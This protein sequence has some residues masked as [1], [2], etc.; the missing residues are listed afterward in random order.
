MIGN[1]HTERMK[2]GQSTTH[3][4]SAVESG[5]GELSQVGRQ[6]YNLRSWLTKEADKSGKKGEYVKERKYI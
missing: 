5:G 3:S 2:Q 1:S 4:L 6:Q